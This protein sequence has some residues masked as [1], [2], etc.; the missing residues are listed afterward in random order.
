M[1]VSLECCSAVSP[2]NTQNAPPHHLDV[3]RWRDEQQVIDMTRQ[4]T[5]PCGMAHERSQRRPIKSHWLPE[6]AAFVEA[7]TGPQVAT[8][9]AQADTSTSRSAKFDE[10]HCWPLCRWSPAGCDAGPAELQGIAGGLCIEAECPVGD[11]VP[12]LGSWPKVNDPVLLHC[13]PAGVPRARQL[14]SSQCRHGC[15]SL[16]GPD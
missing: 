12:G 3:E 14:R 10:H 8:Y 11:D 5:C 15:C 9:G 1:P 6:P 2:H 16:P 4:P 7:P 13:L